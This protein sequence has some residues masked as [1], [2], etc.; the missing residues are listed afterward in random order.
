MLA[1]IGGT[2]DD[3]RHVLA[4][5]L[6]ILVKWEECAI[7]LGTNIVAASNRQNLNGS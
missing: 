6:V 2:T 7:C 1:I 4:H 5:K 3:D